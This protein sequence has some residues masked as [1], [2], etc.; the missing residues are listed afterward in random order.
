MA[1]LLLIACMCAVKKEFKKSKCM[2]M[3][4]NDEWNELTGYIMFNGWFTLLKYV[5][6]ELLIDMIILLVPYIWHLSFFP[7]LYRNTYR[8]MVLASL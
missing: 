7:P 2:Y 5:C 8:K 4:K 6:F 1:P 3:C